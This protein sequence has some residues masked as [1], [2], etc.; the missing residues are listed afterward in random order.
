MRFTVSGSH[1]AG[2]QG[3]RPDRLQLQQGM[4]Q[5]STKVQHRPGHH[6]MQQLAWVASGS[7]WIS[8]EARAQAQPQK[9]PK[10]FQ[11]SSFVVPAFVQDCDCRGSAARQR[12]TRTFLSTSRRAGQGVRAHLQVG[13]AGWWRSLDLHRA[14]RGL[15]AHVGIADATILSGKHWPPSRATLI[16]AW[17]QHW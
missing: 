3:S 8:A 2:Q 9:R 16:P 1:R 15:D 17:T 5:A 13:V 6:E 12:T 14:G 10:G 7:Y 4:Y 11:R